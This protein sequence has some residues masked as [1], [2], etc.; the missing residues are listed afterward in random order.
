VPKLLL[1]PVIAVVATCLCLA[2]LILVGNCFFY[3]RTCPPEGS[4]REAL[5]DV[6]MAACGFG[7]GR[8][9]TPKT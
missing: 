3:Q 1:A 5:E 4:L 9:T 2:F 8:Y 6:L 7:A